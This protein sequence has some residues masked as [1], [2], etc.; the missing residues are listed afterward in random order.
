M[1]QGCPHVVDDDE[2]RAGRQR[3]HQHLPALGDVTG[4]VVEVPAEPAQQTGL[5]LPHVLAGG[6]FS[7]GDPMDAAG[8][9]TR[10]PASHGRG[11]HRLAGAALALQSGDSDQTSSRH[12]SGE[13]VQ[14]LRFD[15]VLG[16]LGNPIEYLDRARRL[17]VSE[18]AWGNELRGDG[19]GRARLS[20][21][22]RPLVHRPCMIAD[23][24]GKAGEDPVPHGIAAVQEKLVGEVVDE[25]PGAQR[26][27][28][29]EIVE[30]EGENLEPGVP[31]LAGPDGSP[32]VVL[33]VVRLIPHVAD[34]D[35]RA[36]GA[37]EG[38]ENHVGELFPHV[39]IAHVTP[40][41]QLAAPT[42]RGELCLHLG[43]KIPL[44]PRIAYEV[45]RRFRSRHRCT[46]HVATCHIVFSPLRWGH[47]GAG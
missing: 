19:G 26:V 27:V 43:D 39:E 45:Q 22:R 7:H 17:W 47:F 24:V 4:R 18:S 8:E 13:R 25:V 33:D 41:V 1:C 15:E 12:L 31:F 40:H 10:G 9:Q 21:R 3:G 38:G 35:D 14:L 44:L 6:T 11:Q 37:L 36:R 34:D 32:F 16:Q 28:A 30:R 46:G 42:S 2:R 29:V 23:Q 20:G 5:H